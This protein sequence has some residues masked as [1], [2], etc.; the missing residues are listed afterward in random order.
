MKNNKNHLQ[1]LIDGFLTLAGMH[2]KINRR[3]KKKGFK[4]NI[5]FSLKT[6]EQCNQEDSRTPLS[7]DPIFIKKI[8]GSN[9]IVLIIEWEN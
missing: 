5:P 2:R 9:Y 8:E 4:G 1:N 3:K 7:K 6:S